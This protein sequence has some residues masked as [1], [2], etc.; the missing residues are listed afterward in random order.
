[1]RYCHFSLYFAA[2][3]LL[4]EARFAPAAPVTGV[5]RETTNVSTRAVTQDAATAISQTIQQGTQQV[6]LLTPVGVSLRDVSATPSQPLSSTAIQRAANE[7]S[8]PVL[9]MPPAPSS[10]ALVMSGV[11]AL[12]AYHGARSLPRLHLGHIPDW[13]HAGATQIGHATPLN[14]GDLVGAAVFDLCFTVPPPAV[15]PFELATFEHDVILI[16][17]VI[18]TRAPRSPPAADLCA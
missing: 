7:S 18:P 14:P 6:T 4:V 1:M 16:P 10:L 3:V 11:L 5:A 8:Q 12:G 2:C 9:S 17:D 15:N 13:Y